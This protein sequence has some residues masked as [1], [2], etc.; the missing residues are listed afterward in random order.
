M[1]ALTLLSLAVLT[2]APATPGLVSRPATE[3]TR[4]TE[5]LVSAY[6]GKLARTHS[7]VVPSVPIP[8]FSR[9]TGLACNACHTSFPQLNAFGRLFKL[10]GYTMTMQ[11]TVQAQDSTRSSLQLDLIPPV[12]AMVISSL[13]SVR[14]DVPDQ[15]N[16]SMAFP[17]E[18]GLFVGEAITPKIG[19]F[20]QLTYDPAE[21]G[22][23]LDNADVRFADH[24]TIGGKDLLYG[25]TMNNSP[26]VQDVWNS[27][28]VWGYPFVG[29]E[30]APGPMASTMM[31]EGLGQTV[32]GVGSYALW[33]NLLY[34]EFTL[35]RSAFQG[36]PVPVDG[37]AENAVH[38][39][40]PYWRVAL[41]HDVAGGQFMVG[42]YGMVS[43]LVPSG[44]EGAWDRYADVALDAQFDKTMTSGASLVAHG[45]WINEN[46]K[47]DAT[48]ADGGA[49]R[50]ASKLR[51]AR[52][53][54]TY[55][56]ASRVGFTAGL[57][58]TSGDADATLYPADPV[59]GSATGSPNSNGYI[60]QFSYMPWLNTRLGLQY[61]GYNKFNG[62]STNYDGAGRDASDNNTLY[63][64]T[65]LVF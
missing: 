46:R 60:L 8:S 57:F 47:L 48:A 15:Q 54:A 16:T 49:D 58:S 37:S 9:Q 26:T 30:V 23:G 14:R 2:A 42:S 51:T 11:Q 62:A 44:F 65:W 21:G 50:V 61:V 12:S 27:T 40:A 24:T 63:L 6:M 17:Q 45:T 34:T 32:M 56:N 22:I 64:M 43:R 59:E 5:A 36:G 29:S 18:L 33:N 20:L 38:G 35:Y 13:S 19:A 39:V 55:Y 1:S 10:N 28:P 7:L 3:A 4:P 25:L 52:V 31:D 53:D 41:Q